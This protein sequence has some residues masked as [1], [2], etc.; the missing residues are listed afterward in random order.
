MNRG[1]SFI[2][3][4]ALVG[5]CVAQAQAALTFFGVDNGWTVSKPDHAAAKAH[6]LTAAGLTQVIDFDAMDLG[7]L[8]TTLAMEAGLLVGLTGGSGPGISNAEVATGNEFGTFAFSG[9]KYFL[10]LGDSGTTQLT[11]TFTQPIRAFGSSISDLGDWG[12]N[13]TNSTHQWVT[14]RGEIYDLVRDK[15]YSH[16]NGNASF[17]GFTTSNPFT[18]ISLIYPTSA[19]GTGLGADGIGIDDINFAV[20]PEPA[21][22]TAIAVGIVALLRRRK[23]G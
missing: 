12:T 11:I 9:A 20:V 7:S 13:S 19:L 5:G 23:Q 10:T 18:S 15:P 21:S 2:I 8:N 14:N 1:Q 16:E 6:F 22:M 17:M 3:S 4:L